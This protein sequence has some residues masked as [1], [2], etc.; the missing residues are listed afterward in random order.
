M[1]L[2]KLSINELKN[3]IWNYNNDIVPVGGLPVREY[4]KELILRCE[5]GKGFHES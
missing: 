4:R 3:A 1:D 5:D 2:S